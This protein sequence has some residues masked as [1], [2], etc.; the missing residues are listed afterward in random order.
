[1]PTFPPAVPPLAP[2]PPEPPRL[3]PAAV[4]A[5]R[6]TPA[7][8]TTVL[9]LSM[10]P[11]KGVWV[12]LRCSGLAGW[13]QPQPVHAAVHGEHG[14]GGRAGQRA[15]EVGDRRGDLLRAHQPATGLARLQRGQLGVGVGGLRE[16]AAYPRRV[17]GTRVHTGDPDALGQVIGRHREREGLNGALGR[18]VQHAL[19]QARGRRDGARIDDRRV[20]VE[21]PCHHWVTSVHIGPCGYAYATSVSGRIVAEK[22]GA[23]GAAYRPSRT[24]TGS[25]KC[26]CRWSTYS[27]TR[28]SIDPETAT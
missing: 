23:S 3:Q 22:P 18:A 6:A 5:T 20:A 11:H 12:L 26:S 9:R 28:S 14:A 13:A 16:Q 7:T 19:G 21:L 24:T 27:M 10:G 8:T 17:R 2:L 1:M 25:T 15:G 4:S